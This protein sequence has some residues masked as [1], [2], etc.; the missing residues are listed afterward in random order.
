MIRKYPNNI[1]D[2]P[3]FFIIG[4]PR[5]GT[6][7]LQ[8]LFE[9]H[10]NVA[11]PPEAPILKQCYYRF[12]KVELWK[13]E[14]LKQLVDF[15]FYDAKFKKWNISKD[16][17]L[18]SF[19][20]YPDTLTFGIIIKIIYCHYISVFP[21]DGIQIFG[22]KNPRYSRDPEEIIK[23]IPNAKIVHVVRDYRDHILSMKRV[24]L[25][26]SNLPLISDVW[27]KSQKKIF[28]LSEKYPD[29]IISFKYEDFVKE[30]EQ[31]LKMICSFLNID[32]VPS[33]LNYAN[34]EKE[35]KKSNELKDSD[36][37]FGNLFKPI[38][39]DNVE[40][41]KRNMTKGDIKR[42]D[43]YIGKYAELSGYKRQVPRR[44][45]TGFLYAFPG[46]I[47]VYSFNFIID[48]INIV[49]IKWRKMVRRKIFRR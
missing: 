45:V 24:K 29:S 37:F 26:Y 18:N 23:I 19:L 39:T 49:P 27:R 44:T 43:F 5:S 15:L 48:I 25:L 34:K 30:P 9:A 42:A 28:A 38:N 12:N 31:H 20:N 2:I 46:Y 4:R 16:E 21:K 22:D 3:F 6:T 41:W 8:T 47:I 11:I 32:Y 10:P 35:V 7:L 1:Q 14:Q 36:V 33:V 40:K 13:K 17:L